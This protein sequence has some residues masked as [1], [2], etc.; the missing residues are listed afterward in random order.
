MCYNLALEAT[1]RRFQ[2]EFGWDPDEGFSGS[3]RLSAFDHPRLPVLR[4]KEGRPSWDWASWGLVTPWQANSPHPER[5]QTLNARWE[6]APEKPSFKDAYANGR[7]AIPVTGFWEWRPRSDS[8]KKELVKIVSTEHAW[9]FLA[10]LASYWEVQNEWTLT[11]L[12]TRAT[13]VVASFHERMPL[14]LTQK[15]VEQWLLTPNRKAIEQEVNQFAQGLRLVQPSP[16]RGHQ[17]EF[18]DDPP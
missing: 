4:V 10:G 14:G 11:V 5:K 8:T 1:R 7:I 15:N 12:T 9:F 13:G 2:E 16:T 3:E 6:T 17:N 18:F